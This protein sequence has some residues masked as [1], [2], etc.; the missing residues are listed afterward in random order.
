M[1]Q[2][3]LKRL[4]SYGQSPWL[5]SIQWPLLRSGRL[6]QMMHRWGIRGVAS[7]PSIFEQS[8]AHSNAAR[9]LKGEIA[10]ASARL[11]YRLFQAGR[12]QSRVRQLSEQ[13]ARPQRLLW[14]STGTKDSKSAQCRSAH[15]RLTMIMADPR[16]DS[17]AT[18]EMR[19][20]SGADDSQRR[21]D[22][23]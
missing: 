3:S 11:A 16:P 17:P 6:E 13:G 14:D 4:L 21:S 7:N 15:L 22:S 10:F 20:R 5:D 2:S 18:K 1:S 23:A 12:R 9:A 19:L 8:I